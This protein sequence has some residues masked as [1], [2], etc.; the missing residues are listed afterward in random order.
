MYVKKVCLHTTG[1]GANDQISIATWNS[2]GFTAAIPFL[3]ELVRVNDVVTIS[4]HWLHENRLSML[5]QVSNNVLFCGRASRF[6]SAENYGCSRGQGGVAIIWNKNITGITE[7]KNIIHDRICVVRLQTL[8][9][10]V[11]FIYSVYLPAQGSSEDFSSVL[12]DLAEIIEARGETSSYVI[13]GDMNADMGLSGGLRNKGT[14]TKHGKLLSSFVQ[15][16]GLVVCNCRVGATGPVETY[17]GP[18]GSSTIDHIMVSADLEGGVLSCSTSDD[19]VLNT[20]D[21]RAVRISLEVGKVSAGGR[22]AAGGRSIRW[23][24]LTR[25]EIQSKY[26]TPLE[27]DLLKVIGKL[28]GSEGTVDKDAID[29]C[30][31]EVVKCLNFRGKAIPTSKFKKNLRPYWNERLTELKKI[32]VLKHSAWVMRGR[33]RIKGDIFWEEHKRARKDFVKELRRLHREYE[34]DSVTNVI[35]AAETD[36]GV[37][38]KLVKKSRGGGGSTISAIK[39]EEGKV[40]NNLEDVLEVWRRHFGKLYTPKDSESFYK[41]HFKTV[42]EKVEGWNLG[43][44]TDDFLSEEFSSQEVRFEIGKLHKRKA[45]GYDGVSTEHIQ[46][47]GEVLVTL[48]TLLYNHIVNLEYIPIN[49]RRGTQI[50]LYKGK[51]A[52]SLITDSYRGITLLTNFNKIYEIMVWERIRGWWAENRVI[53][54]LQGAGRKKQSCV[55]T[56]LLLQEAIADALEHH[57]QVFVAF[58]DVSK[59][60]DTVWTN[61]LFYQLHNMGIRGRTWR[62]LYRAYLD[63]KCRVRI[64]DKCSEWYNMLCGIHQGGFLSSTKYIAFINPLVEELERSD[65]CCRVGVIKA[66]PVSYADDLA[67][68]CISKLRL[69][70][71]LKMVYEFSRKWR[72]DF[73]AGKSAIMTYGEE[74][75][76][77]GKNAIDRVFKL[78]SERIKERAEY[79]HVGVKACLFQDGNNRVDEKISKGRRTLN[80]TAGLGIR[81]NRLNIGTCNLIF[82]VIVMPTVTF[83]C[84][85]WILSDDDVEKLQAFQ[86]YAGRRVQRFPPRSPSCSSYYGLG[87]LR[88]ETYIFVKKLLFLLTMITMDNNHRIKMV[89]RHRLTVYLES[90]EAGERNVHNSP[91]F[92]LFNVCLRFGVLNEVVDMIEGRSVPVAKATW[93]KRVWSK[94]WALDDAYW[95]TMSMVFSEN[96]LLLRTVGR[97]QYLTWWALADRWPHLI[98]ICEILAKIVCRTSRLK[99]DDF[100]LKGASHNQKLCEYCDLATVETINHLI[101]QCASTLDIRIRMYED[102]RAVDPQFDERCAKEPGEIVYWLLGKHIADVDIDVMMEIWKVA[103][104]CIV[105]MYHRMIKR[106]EGVG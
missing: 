83:G 75:K 11:I 64:G 93:S 58:Y 10:G 100:R 74:R 82:W 51:K 49:L 78:G 3:R 69:D 94:A 5:E 68:A 24:K 47:A 84:E 8:N 20:S 44:D 65:L 36:R 6:A 12:D 104:V 96:G 87:W 53:S 41:E 99:C 81:Q 30:I 26:T 86:R 23:E 39:N 56:A 18:T 28:Q 27:P 57:N 29:K 80:A 19:N 22:N 45:S 67:T 102:I 32:K 13:C 34:N 97:S 25:E 7:V 106:R 61:G 46:Y 62:L 42:N 60:Y 91:I 37:F 85:I 40:V 90:R 101:M 43:E 52:C 71:V 35:N 63:F 1:A 103:G 70:R 89:L 55:H 72:F 66:S 48:L 14:P 17:V 50:P 33:P 38:W 4:E 95:H 9:G 59:A 88:L 2:R 98:R 21:H 76:A 73:N 105:E 79:D 16:F 54:D 77:N 92:D 31:D 15:E